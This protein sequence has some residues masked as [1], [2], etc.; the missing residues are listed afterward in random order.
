MKLKEANP[1]P[2]AKLAIVGPANVGKTVF[3]CSNCA[4]P[5][6]ALDTDGRFPDYLNLLLQRSDDPGEVPED[7]SIYTD[8]VRMYNETRAAQHGNKFRAV[9]VDSMTKPFQGLARTAHLLNRSQRSGDPN[10]ASANMSDRLQEKAMFIST[11]SSITALFAECW[12]TWHQYDGKDASGRDRVAET[13]SKTERERLFQSLSARLDFG[14]DKKGYWVKP[15]WARDWR[16]ITPNIGFTM[17]DRPN[18][19]WAGGLDRLFNIM[20]ASFTGK[21]DAISVASAR[22]GLTIEELSAQ[23][24]SLRAGVSKSSEMW[25]KWALYMDGVKPGS[26]QSSQEPIAPS[27]PDQAPTEDEIQT[28]HWEEEARSADNEF[29]FVTALHKLHPDNTYDGLAEIRKRVCS[30]DVS[31]QNAA[32]QF[33]ATEKYLSTYDD[34]LSAS[35]NKASAYKAALVAAQEKYAQLK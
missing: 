4:L 28:R 35:G 33:V 13:I 2:P 12:L 16:G 1:R 21:D 29:M 20:Y 15:V 22:T 30:D 24:E 17:H 7:Q 10:V 14:S 27:L 11:I 32:A 5:V 9:V 26:E 31:A 34:S 25:Y 3:I 19:F 23:Y 18:N 8:T 6:W